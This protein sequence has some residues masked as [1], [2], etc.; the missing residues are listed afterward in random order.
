MTTQHEVYPAPG[1]VFDSDR[2]WFTTADQASKELRYPLVAIC[3]TCQQ[4]ITRGSGE[5]WRHGRPDDHRFSRTIE[6]RASGS[7]YPEE[8]SDEFLSAADDASRAHDPTGL[9]E[10][11]INGTSSAALVPLDLVQYALRHGWGR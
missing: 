7:Y 8:V 3:Y 5:D 1:T 11:T 9:V 2:Q 4:A 10:V 6:A